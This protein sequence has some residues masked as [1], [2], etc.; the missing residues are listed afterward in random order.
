MAAYAGNLPYGKS[1]LFSKQILISI[2][3]NQL[4]LSVSI[5]LRMSGNLAFLAVIAMSATWALVTLTTTGF[6]DPSRT[7][8]FLGLAYGV[9]LL[10]A[11]LV[12]MAELDR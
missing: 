9:L 10:F 1:A 11:L 2:E 5:S 6:L 12:Y 3:N 8:G 4:P 7:P